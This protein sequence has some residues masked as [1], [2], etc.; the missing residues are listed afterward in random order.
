MDINLNLKNID[1][2]LNL[3]LVDIQFHHMVINPDKR[4]YV[5]LEDDNEKQS[6]VEVNPYEASMISFVQK[7]LHTNSHINTIHQLFIKALSTSQSKIEEIAI[8]SKVGDIIYCSMKMVD[9]KNNRVFSILSLADAL[10]LAKIT[11]C[12][13]K[14]LTSVWENFDTIDE[15]DYEDY[16]ID[17]DPDDD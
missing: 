15:W 17:I 14:A 6:G 12:P 3:E 10:I 5:V 2:Q 8:E 9:I 4:I 11:S 13:L 16:I 1:N 7:G